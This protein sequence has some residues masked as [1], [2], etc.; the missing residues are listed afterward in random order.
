MTADKEKER[1]KERDRDRDRDR[2]KREA[3]KSRRQDGDRGDRESESSRPRRSCTLEGGAK[4]YAESEH[5]EDDDNENGSTGGGS[6]TAEEACKKGK[7]KTPKKKSRYER[8]ENGEITSFITEDDVVYR[9][10]DCVYIESRRPNTPYFICSIQDFK[11]SK[12]DHLLMNVKWYYRQSEVPDSVYQHLVQDRNNENDSGRDLVITDPV[13]RSRELF[14]S[15]YVDTYHAA[16][17]RGKCNISHFS[18]IFAAR[19]FKARI[20]SFFYILGYNPETRRLNSTQGEI[21]V[22]PSHQAKLPELQ[23]FPSPGGQAVTENE[24]LVWMPGVNDC[25]LLMYLRAARSMA[26]F[27]GM[28]DGGSTEDGC[29]AAS[30]DDTTLNALNT[31]HES[32][33]DAGK[34][35]QRLVKKP[36]PKLIEKCWS[37]DE[38]KRFIKGLRQ[39]GKNFFRIR[40]ELLPNKETGE[41]ITFY[42]YWKKTPEAASCRAHRRHRRQPV[43]RRIKTRTA[44]TPV[45]TPSRPPSSEFLDLSSASEDDFDSEDSE[46]ELKGYACRHCFT[47]TSKDWHHG[48]RENI[49][50]CTD[51][52]IHFKKYGELPPIEKPV[53]P[54][55]FMF[56]PVKEEEDGLSGKHS[57]RTRRNRGSMSTLRSGRKK[58]TASPDGRA[59]PTNEDLRSS[60]RTSPSAASTDSTD[61][62]TDSMKKPSKKIKEEAPSPMKSAKRQREKGAS[63][64]EEPERASAKKSKTQELSRPDSPSECEGEGEGESSDGRSINEELSS[65]PKD[66]DQDNRSSS[67]SIPSPR[68]NES[69]SDSSA[70]QQQL[71]QSQHPPVIQCQPGT[72]AASSAPP[73]PTTSAPSLP[74]QVSPTAASTSL[75]PQPLPQAS[76]MSLIQ[77]GAPLHPQRLPSPH[78]PMTQALPPGP[79]VPPQSL[80]SS[81]HGPMPPMPHPLQPGPSHMPHPH[82]MP[83]QGFP[84]GQSQVPPLPISGQSQQRP[85]T[86]PSQSQS[87]AQSVSQPPREQPLPPAPMSMPHIKPPPTTPIP[88]LPNPQSHK[89]PPHVSAPP[90][91]QMPSNLPPPPALKPLSSLSNHHPPSA[92]P[93]PLQLMPQGQQLQPPPAQPPVLTQ[94]QSLPPSASHQPPPAPPLPP[95]AAASHPNGPPQPPFSSHPFSTVLPP[96]GPPPSSSNSMPGI[97]PPS[98]STPSSSISMPLPP[99]VTCAGPGPVLPP[100]HIKEEP[101]DESEE[102]ES[103]PPPQRSP[104]PEPTVVNTPSH[105]S[106]SARFYK[107]LDRG[108]NSCARTDFYFTPLA[109]SKLAKKREEALEKAKREAEQ[110]A[111]EEK[112]R[113]REREKERERER[114]REKEAERAAKASSSSHEGRMDPQMAGPAHMRPPFDG[115]PTTIAAVPPYIG[116][117]TP[118][119]RTLSEYARPHVMS[120]TNRNHPFF[121]SLNP[122][123]QLLA[124]HMPSLY[125]ADPAMRERELR[126]REMREREIREREL[127]E[128]MKPGFEVKPPEM[129]SMHPSTNPMEHFARHGAITLPPMAGPHPFASFHPGLNPLERERLALAGPQLRPEMSYPERLAAERLHAERMA[130]VANDPIARLQMFNVTPH[131]HQHSHI[132]SHLHL[133]QQDPLHQGGG[134]CLVCPPGSGG[135]PLAVDPLGAGPHLARFPYPPGAIPNPLLGQPPHEHE[136]LRHPVFGTPYP[137]DLPGGL[138]P[139]MSAAHQ[140]QA[141]HAQSAE[142]QRLAMEQQWLHG[143]HHMHGGPLPGQEDY[144]SRLKKESDKQL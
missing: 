122:A 108:Y 102:P 95:S 47:T 45:N 104:S 74:P 140:L 10:G 4:N 48:G 1:E 58:Q 125:N 88:Q 115:P 66:I 64:T 81:H 71:L 29:L 132:H 18:D 8:T 84:V 97:Q 116:P 37:E 126:E 91:P 121:V 138:P 60:G 144:Y 28:C 82:S 9:P 21:R 142:L 93:P 78:S 22:G 120:P 39:F 17:L 43:F 55:P 57:M 61:S 59:S 35:L 100:V 110:K 2:D 114:E 26:A 77:S 87:A 92:H 86:P 50:L 63:D 67:P 123:D 30:R 19:E 14:I 24:E 133:H 34:A 44:S 41:L 85:H 7:K 80:P 38:V 107:H 98:S 129:D 141:M 109:S 11:L 136:M 106:Q 96:T 143:H 49:L 54:P 113:E 94:S 20:D 27:A 99:S 52:R 83:P 75:P 23:P 70:Q 46:Q 124:Y 16:A 40:K 32:S 53:D 56:K 15:D 137:R 103:P 12:R 72:S 135:H 134:E 6:G 13:V 73:P 105:A 62:K 42:Y 119:L 5:S 90:F 51:C 131:H 130:T 101:L 89:H 118:A 139:P 111:R 69:D 31:L 65:D 117:D 127:R 25:D 36:V 68:D 33:Y 76:P 128:R 3:G 79:S 112:E